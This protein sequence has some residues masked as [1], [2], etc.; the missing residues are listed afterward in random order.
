MH[1]HVCLVASAVRVPPYTTVTSRPPLVRSCCCCV[2]LVRC[3]LARG[4]SQVTG[5]SGAGNLEEA[6]KDSNIVV[7]PAGV[8]RKPGMSRDDLFNTNASIVAELAAA[9]AVACPDAHI[10]VIANPVNSTVPIVAE[11]M[12]KA[13]KYNPKKCVRGGGGRV[14]R[15]GR[16]ALA[17]IRFALSTTL[18]TP[19]HPSPIP[20]PA[21]CSA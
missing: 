13:G 12:K 1:T 21:G 5:L 18:T 17:S 8:P 11:V 10:L 4:V 16:A 2:S 7:I 6:I 20:A 19:H 15:A 3:P 9:C 14:A